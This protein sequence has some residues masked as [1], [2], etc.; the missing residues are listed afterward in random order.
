MNLELNFL[1]KNFLLN[2]RVSKKRNFKQKY[3]V[4]F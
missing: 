2:C 3:N 1:R 4:L